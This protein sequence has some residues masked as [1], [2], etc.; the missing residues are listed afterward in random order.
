MFIND[1]IAPIVNRVLRKLGIKDEIK[2]LTYDGNAT[3]DK[4]V[5]VHG[6][7]FAEIADKAIAPEAIVRVVATVGG[8]VAE[9]SKGEL[10]IQ[11]DTDDVGGRG[12]YVFTEWEGQQMPILSSWWSA[13]GS[14]VLAVL[15][16]SDIG[17]YVSRIETETI[18]PID[19]K[20]LPGVCLPVVVDFDELGITNCVLG[21][22][23]ENGGTEDLFENN[24]YGVD[25]DRVCQAFPTG[26]GFSAKLTVPNTGV[27]HVNPVYTA[28]GPDFKLAHFDS[29]LMNDSGLLKFY[30]RITCTLDHVRVVAGFY[31]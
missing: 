6:M 9:K 14:E 11:W 18:T 17:A 21:L 10:A 7:M 26:A 3:W 28:N 27:M 22:F 1:A 8:N 2:V 24:P 20:Y 12:Y 19:P 30:V 15:S 4:L 29:Y 13:N 31:A 25:V 16:D 23:D 5:S